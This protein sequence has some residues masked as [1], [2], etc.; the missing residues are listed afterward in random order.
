MKNLALQCVRKRQKSLSPRAVVKFCIA[1]A[2]LEGSRLSLSTVKAIITIAN[3]KVDKDA[4][5]R[6]ENQSSIRKRTPSL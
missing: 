5:Y 2:S 1:N 4:S 3:K 6:L